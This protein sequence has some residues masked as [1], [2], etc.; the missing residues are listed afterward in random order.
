MIFEH[1]CKLGFEG[2]VSKRIDLPY[3][4]GPSKTWQKV[5]NK[6]HAAVQRVRE[7]FE[8]KRADYERLPTAPQ[9]E[10]V[11][12]TPARTDRQRLGR[13][14]QSD[15]NCSAHAYSSHGLA[16]PAITI[17]LT[18]F[19]APRCARRPECLR[20]YQAEWEE[21][22]RTFKKTPKHDWASSHGARMPFAISQRLDASQ[23]TWTR[24]TPKL[25]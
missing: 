25:N 3:E 15:S 19:D 4:P 18:R 6:E 21:N 9:K 1:A 8:R 12:S 11:E 7:A 14:R 20:S 2:V 5:K 16:P 13:N 24:T 22:L 10:R 17:P 23:W